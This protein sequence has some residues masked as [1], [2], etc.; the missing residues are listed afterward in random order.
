RIA[1]DV[2]N[3]A[4]VATDH[5]FKA[6]AQTVGGLAGDLAWSLEFSMKTPEEQY[7]QLTPAAL[8]AT[9]L[10]LT[11]LNNDVNRD[12]Y[13]QIL[14]D[15]AVRAVQQEVQLLQRDPATFWG[16]HSLDVAPLV[17]KIP[18]VVGAGRRL[19]AVAWEAHGFQKA[20]ATGLACRLIQLPYKVDCFP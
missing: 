15:E 6:L 11:Y 3:N 2:Q 4:L 13:H 18:Q 5:F 16:K 8:Q 10:V 20:S 19:A 17:G 1:T 9:L 12:H 14:H 7:R